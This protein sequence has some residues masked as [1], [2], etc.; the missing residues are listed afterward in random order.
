MASKLVIVESPS[1]AK[2][3]AKYLGKDY[4]IKASMGH[5]RDLPEKEL[6]VDVENNFAPKYSI[7]GN[8]KKTVDDLRSSASKVKQVFLATDPDREGEAIAWHIATILEKQNSNIQRVMFN[9]IT[10]EAVRNAVANPGEIDIRKVD[11]QQA[12]RVLDRLVGYKVSEQLWKV[13]ARGL[14]AGRV[15]SV[16]L[17]MI[18]E[19]QKEIDSFIPEEFWTITAQAELEESPRFMMKLVKMAGKEAKITGK[20]LAEEVI[21]CLKTCDAELASIKNRVTSQNPPPPFITST[22]QQEAARRLYYSVKRTMVIAQKLYEGIELGKDGSVGL[23]TYMRTDST[24]M[25]DSAV[26]AARDFIQDKYGEE[27]LYSKPRSFGKKKGAQ[28]AH[29]A[30]RPTSMEWSPDRVKKFLTKEQYKLYE[31]IWNRF[32]ATQM[33]AAKY[34][35]VT[36]E[37]GVGKIGD[38]PA[39]Q[40]SGKKDQYP[41]LLR[42]TGRRLL[43]AGFRKL[44]GEY[45]PE[46]NGDEEKMDTGNGE[47]SELPDVFFPKSAGKKKIPVTEGAEVSL[48]D[49]KGTQKFTQPPAQYSEST[50]VKALDEK[51]IGRPSTY[52]QIISTLLDRKYVERDKRKLGP[53]ELGVTVSDLL[54]QEFDDVFNI[55]FTARMEQALDEVEEGKSWTDTVRR[56]WEPFSDHIEKF[57]NRRGEIKK[58]SMVK[59]GRKCPECGDGELVERWGRYGKFISCD[60]FPKCKYM[61]KVEGESKK[62]EPEKTGKTCPTCNE[63]ELV[64]RA[65]RYGRFLSCSRYPKCKHTEQIQ[66]EK[67]QAKGKSV[68]DISIP[69]PREG[70]GGTIVA[71]RTRR[72]RIMYGCT[73]WKEKKCGVA[74]WDRPVESKCPNCGYALRVIKGKNLLCPECNHKEAHKEDSIDA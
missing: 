45:V 68:P 61:E 8:K 33:T 58:N 56:F 20:D 54:V 72:G 53:T 13:I 65:G 59:I 16:A 41:Y 70:C 46:N 17:R 38:A 1:K 31:L 32:L 6:A 5:V 23:I 34:E 14:S 18:V 74:F 10:K 44:W 52:A 36:V 25:A 67:D 7:I 4:T 35:G 40:K 30:I 62:Q 64:I 2:T 37:V 69:C 43:F 3:L 51:G 19:R 48:H 73:N 49:I 22:L 21:K 9:E 47:T 66:G 71:K 24:R 60:Q 29:E 26:A 12:R 28:D 15:Q 42:T 27:Y 55:K 11:A 63:G 50:L 39:G 57:S